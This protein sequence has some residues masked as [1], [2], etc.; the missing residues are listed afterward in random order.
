MFIPMCCISV[1]GRL[2]TDFAEN[3]TD[4]TVLCYQLY[5]GTDSGQ[6]KWYNVHPMECM[7][8]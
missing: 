6:I 8:H 2:D 5:I 7:I 4:F 3:I 1:N